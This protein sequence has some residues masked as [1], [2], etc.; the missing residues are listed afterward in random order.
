[1]LK[2]IQNLEEGQVPGEKEWAKEGETMLVTRQDFERLKEYFHD[3]SF[4]AQ[5]G[6]CNLMEQRTR[7]AR[8][9]GINQC[10][11]VVKESRA[12]AEVEL[13]SGWNQVEQQVHK[14]KQVDWKNVKIIRRTKP[15]RDYAP[16]IFDE[17]DQRVELEF[18]AV[19]RMRLGEERCWAAFTEGDEGCP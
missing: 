13:W 9:G 12:M 10:E 3:S 5:R 1:M 2:E 4:M 19:K 11:D 6:M 17:E 15:I 14:I 16:F 8:N 18:E 7:D